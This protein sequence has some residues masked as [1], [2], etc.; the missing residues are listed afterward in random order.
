MHLNPDLIVSSNLNRM[1]MMKHNCIIIYFVLI[2]L[3]PIN[4]QDIDVRY[5]IQEMFNPPQ[6]NA[7]E[8]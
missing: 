2:Y 1:N 6:E 8:K 7:E 5:L 3:I 4:G